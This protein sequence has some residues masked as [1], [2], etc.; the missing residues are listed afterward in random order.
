MGKISPRLF[1][2]PLPPWPSGSSLQSRIHPSQSPRPQPSLFSQHIAAEGRM[3]LAPDAGCALPLHPAPALACR[4]QVV[5]G[6]GLPSVAF[7]SYGCH[8]AL[9]S[10]FFFKPRGYNNRWFFICCECSGPLETEM[11]C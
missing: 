6:A 2:S 5:W 4:A 1:I 9:Q 11:T 8:L 3:Q 10:A 7:S